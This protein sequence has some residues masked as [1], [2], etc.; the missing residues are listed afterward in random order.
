MTTNS[1]ITIDEYLLQI[2]SG[3][4]IFSGLLN[5]YQRAVSIETH[6][7]FYQCQAPQICYH[8]TYELLD[9]SVYSKLYRCADLIA[10][11]VAAN[12]TS[13]PDLYTHTTNAFQSADF[14]LMLDGI[15]SMIIKA[16]HTIGELIGL[17]DK[18]AD[19]RRNGKNICYIFRNPF[20]TGNVVVAPEQKL[21]GTAVLNTIINQSYNEKYRDIFFIGE[22][23]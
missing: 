11:G 8:F 19:Y 10:L 18:V 20:I 2:Y 12:T 6:Q 16:C 3:K 1:S 17:I 7:F 15:A 14:S 23:T 5:V 4:N 13:M 21:F 9:G 22:G